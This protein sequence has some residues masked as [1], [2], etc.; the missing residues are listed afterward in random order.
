MSWRLGPLLLLL[1]SFRL[2]KSEYP[3]SW[4]LGPLL[5]LLVDFRLSKSEYPMSWRLGLLFFFVNFSLYWS[6]LF[7]AVKQFCRF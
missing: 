3:I 1:V 5:L 7:G 6:F 2:S 4:R